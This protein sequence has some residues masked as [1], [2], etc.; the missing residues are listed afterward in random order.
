M[1]CVASYM[2]MKAS[3]TEIS[4][5]EWDWQLELRIF[6]LFISGIYF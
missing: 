3:Q 2:V 5:F 1:I 4:S 6:C